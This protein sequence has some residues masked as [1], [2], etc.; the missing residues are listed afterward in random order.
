MKSKLLS[1]ALSLVAAVAVAEPIRL[2]EQPA[3][4]DQ[5]GYRPAN[6][7]FGMPVHPCFWDKLR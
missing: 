1:L 4:D 5:W 7:M 2:D 3:G 6:G